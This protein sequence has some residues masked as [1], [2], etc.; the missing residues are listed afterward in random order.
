MPGQPDFYC[1]FHCAARDRQRSAGTHRH[2]TGSRPL[3]TAFSSG[4]IRRGGPVVGHP[5][6]RPSGSSGVSSIS[7]RVIPAGRRGIVGLVACSMSPTGTDR[8]GRI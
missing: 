2:A 6:G 5:K 1:L 8:R 7:Q 4:P 3:P